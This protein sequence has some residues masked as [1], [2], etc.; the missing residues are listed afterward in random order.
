MSSVTL[1]Q[2]PRGIWRLSLSR[3]EVAK[4]AGCYPHPRKQTKPEPSAK[5][6][7]GTNF[8]FNKSLLFIQKLTIGFILQIF[9]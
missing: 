2:S 3:D 9:F 5:T 6:E 8:L 4:S 1:P 7:D